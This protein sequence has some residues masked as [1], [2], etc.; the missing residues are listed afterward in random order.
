MVNSLTSPFVLQWMVVN[1]QGLLISLRGGQ[2]PVS[3][4]RRKALAYLTLKDRLE[5]SRG[6]S[7]PDDFIMGIIMAT[8]AESR[9][10][11]PGVSNV[12]LKAY[13]AVV[14]GRGGLR[15]IILASSA[16]PIPSTCH[17]MPYIVSE[18]PPSELV[19]RKDH[20]DQAIEVLQFLARGENNVD[21]SKLI[22]STTTTATTQG[23]RS[24]SRLESSSSLKLTLDDEDVY[25]PPVVSRA[26]EPFLQPDTWDYPRYI[27]ISSHFQALFIMVSTLW[28][29]RRTALLQQFFLDRV[30]RI[31][32][33]SSAQDPSS[34]KYLL[35]L[36]GFSW[37][38]VKA[39]LEV[40]ESFGDKEVTHANQVDMMVDAV[41]ALKLL[42]VCCGSVRRKLIAFLCECLDDVR[43]IPSTTGAGLR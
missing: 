15:S 1:A 24:S 32:V 7:L 41:C 19:F 16:G 18:L 17:F 29:L 27:K 6:E 10:S 12:H 8:V 28:K 2:E 4:F 42:M 31:F 34:G 43:E 33:M 22:F 21:P 39:A 3:F 37:V 35:N 36:E 38:V 26:L 30:H 20:A 40:Y 5:G 23:P 9:I 13:E 11:P 14:A 25:D